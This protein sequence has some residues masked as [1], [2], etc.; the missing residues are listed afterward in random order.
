MENC[1]NQNQEEF[2]WEATTEN[3]T[4]EVD[5]LKE[6]EELEE[7]NN[8]VKIFKNI[9]SNLSSNEGV[10]RAEFINHF[11]NN[12]P[13]RIWNEKMV[14]YFRTKKELSISENYKINRKIIETNIQTIPNFSIRE[15][16]FQTSTIEKYQ[17][18]K[19]VEDPE[20]WNL[21]P[22][23]GDYIGHKTFALVAKV[24]TEE[25]KL[26]FKQIFDTLKDMEKELPYFSEYILNIVNK[27]PLT[28]KEIRKSGIEILQNNSSILLDI[29]RYREDKEFKFQPVWNCIIRN[30]I[31]IKHV[32][33]FTLDLKSHILGNVWIDPDYRNQKLGQKILKYIITGYLPKIK[34][35]F[36][37]TKNPAMAKIIKKCHTWNQDEGGISVKEIGRI[38]GYETEIYPYT[39]K[40]KSN[41]EPIENLFIIE[42]EETDNCF[43]HLLAHW[44]NELF[45][46]LPYYP[47]ISKYINT[48]KE[49]S[50]NEI[51]PLLTWQK[52]QEVEDP[53]IKILNINRDYETLPEFY[54]P[55]LNIYTKHPGRILEIDGDYYFL[56]IFDDKIYLP[57]TEDIRAKLL[58]LTNEFEI[59]QTEKDFIV[60]TNKSTKPEIFYYSKTGHPE[61]NEN[62]LK[63]LFE[64]RHIGAE[65]IIDPIK[66]QCNK[67]SIDYKNL[68]ISFIIEDLV[69]KKDIIKYY[70]E[71]NFLDNL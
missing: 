40:E 24:N 49:Y 18:W 56:P 28:Q 41:L 37:T 19:I 4:N 44:N 68:I 43:E 46:H 62:I 30:R 61:L 53:K 29:L 20:F 50:S 10:E 16:R 34:Y 13:D 60:I 12:L 55:Y 1:Q 8:S 67:I 32:G 64:K 47:T 45:V 6:L 66:N 5:T 22:E 31:E 52:R 23:I 69:T 21:K 42:S 11:Y 58:R 7:F 27:I 33:Y 59:H 48:T 51:Y 39:T 63:W 70:N 65:N 36:I 3:E 25:I 17:S 9:I 14:K 71:L 54:N 57:L 38:F 2:S 15:V 26:P 35:I